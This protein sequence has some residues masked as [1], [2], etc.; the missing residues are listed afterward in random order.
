MQRIPK[1]NKRINLLYNLCSGSTFA[2]KIIF[3]D[4][5]ELS[6]FKSILAYDILQGVG[7]RAI[8]E[9]IKLCFR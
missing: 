8:K 3:P 4:I 1:V 6:G 2:L 9:Y 7:V 5:K